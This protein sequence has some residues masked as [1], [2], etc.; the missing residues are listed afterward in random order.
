MTTNTLFSIRSRSRVLRMRNFSDRICTETQN[1]HF[2][3]NNFFFLIVSFVRCAKI[4]YSRPDHRWQYN[5]GH[6]HAHY[7]LKKH[8]LNICNNYCFSTSAVVAQRASILRY[9]CIACLVDVHLEVTR[10]IA[11]HL[12]PACIGCF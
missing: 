10:L 6:E 5:N 1:T 8:A 2:M 11:S 7:I 12:R 9:T 3:S 4:F